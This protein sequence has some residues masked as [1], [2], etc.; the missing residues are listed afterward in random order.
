[1]TTRKHYSAVFKAQVVTR[2]LRDDKTLAQIAAE[3]GVHPNQLSQ[4]KATV[5]G[6]MPALFE[7]DESTQ[8]AE[9][10]AQEKQ[11]AE[12]Y[13]QIGRLTTQLAWIKKNLAATLSRSERLAFIEREAEEA[14]LSAQADL[15]SVSRASL[16]YQPALPP[17]AEMAV[18][19]RIDE[20]YTAWPRRTGG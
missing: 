20:I 7:K 1:M 6:A 5:L 10:A 4:W 11:V 8:A 18:K 13:D 9:K 19:R 12:L 15:L 17:A 16:Y 3:H 2:I 14:P